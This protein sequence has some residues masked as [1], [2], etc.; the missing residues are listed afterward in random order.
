MGNRINAI[1]RSLHPLYTQVR[2]AHPVH[3]DGHDPACIHN[4]QVADRGS[5]E[6][7]VGDPETRVEQQA[8]MVFWVRMMAH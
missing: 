1:H 2:N 6:V 4:K 5:I 3:M 8:L 7:V